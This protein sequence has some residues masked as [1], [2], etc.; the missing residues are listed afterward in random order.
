MLAVD[1]TI[2]WLVADSA[3]DEMHTDRE[4]TANYITIGT[5]LP[6][7]Y[8]YLS[9]FLYARCECLHL[10]AAHEGLPRV[11]MVT[12]EHLVAAVLTDGKHIRNICRTTCGPTTPSAGERER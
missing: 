12:P 1:G 8:T 11:A 5:T 4:M 7:I 2:A 10:L 3:V 6:P 9:G